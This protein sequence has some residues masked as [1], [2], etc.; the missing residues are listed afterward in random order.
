[1]LL[2]LFFRFYIIFWKRFHAY[3]QASHRLWSHVKHVHVRIFV[4]LVH[5]HPKFRPHDI[6]KFT[7]E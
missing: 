1:M 7:I 4:S 6:H 2:K 3:G 5:L